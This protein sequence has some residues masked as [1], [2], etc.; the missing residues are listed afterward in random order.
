MVKAYDLVEAARMLEG[1]YYRWWYVGASLPMWADDG[2]DHPPV[3]YI[4]DRGVMCS[5]LLNWARQEC[6]LPSIGGTSDYSNALVDWSA[7]DPDTPGIPGAVCVNPYY[8]PVHQGHV[9][10]YTGEHQIIQSLVNPGVTEAYTDTQTHEWE[11]CR[12]EWYGFMADVDYSDAGDVSPGAEFPA[13]R[14]N[15]W[16]EQEDDLNLTYHGP[17]A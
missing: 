14:R 2:Y 17:S 12:F 9:A 16:Y 11:G 7:F 10:L 6:G 5:D 3:S 8:S 15:G 4:M 13:W 1:A